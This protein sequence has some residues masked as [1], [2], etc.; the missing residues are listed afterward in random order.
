MSDVSGVGTYRTTFNL[1]AGWSASNGAYFSVASTGDGNTQITVNGK[2]AADLDL[3]TLQVDISD[4]L[5]PG[6]NTIE[7]TVK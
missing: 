2:R 7:V 6:A 5:I 3:R 4:L 1:P